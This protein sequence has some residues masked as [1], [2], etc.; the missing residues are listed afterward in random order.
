MMQS[1]LDVSKAMIPYGVLHDQMLTDVRDERGSMTFRFSIREDSGGWTANG[2][3][4][5]IIKG[6]FSPRYGRIR[7]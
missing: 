6:R 3:S 1:E 7:Q 4:G 2:I 5:I